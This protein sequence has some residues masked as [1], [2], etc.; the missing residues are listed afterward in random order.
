MP[1]IIAACLNIPHDKPSRPEISVTRPA[2]GSS[3]FSARAYFPA[4]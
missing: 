1:S 4:K 2:A 3:N